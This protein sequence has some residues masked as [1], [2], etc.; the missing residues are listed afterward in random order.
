LR[1]DPSLTRRCKINPLFFL[2]PAPGPAWSI[3][4]PVDGEVFRPRKP[5]FLD[6]LRRFLLIPQR[7]TLI[8]RRPIQRK[9]RPTLR[10]LI[11]P[12]RKDCFRCREHRQQGIKP[13]QMEGFRPK[14]AIWGL[15]SGLDSLRPSASRKLAGRK[16][17]PPLNRNG[18]LGGKI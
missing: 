14:T 16:S 11:F 4:P 3:H 5:S 12:C 13:I 18:G 2:H 17:V 7:K 8:G 9:L 15:I 1:S 6:V 10:K